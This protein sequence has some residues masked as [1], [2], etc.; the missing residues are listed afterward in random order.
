MKITAYN[1]SKYKT[2]SVHY[3]DK[4][5]GVNFPEEMDDEEREGLMSGTFT[6]LLTFVPRDNHIGEERDGKV[7]IEQCM[8]IPVELI[9]SIEDESDEEEGEAYA[10]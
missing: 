5:L 7:C 3:T 6:P 1:T 4:I 8:A 2:I 10:D 9:I